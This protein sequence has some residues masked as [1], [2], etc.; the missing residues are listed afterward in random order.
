[1]RRLPVCF[2]FALNETFVEEAIVWNLR[3]VKPVSYNYNEGREGYL[4]SRLEII[5]AAD[6]KRKII[7]EATTSFD[8]LSWL[9]TQ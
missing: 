7:H 4:G 6:G 3:I 2:F 9:V 1:M 8:A 5:Q